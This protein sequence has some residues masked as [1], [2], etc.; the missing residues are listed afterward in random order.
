MPANALL[1]EMHHKIVNRKL[2]M[3]NAFCLCNTIVLFK[4]SPK[5]ATPSDNLSQIT[6]WPALNGTCVELKDQRQKHPRSLTFEMDME[7]WLEMKET[8]HVGST[9]V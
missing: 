7:I 2:E 9:A 8:V 3:L 1:F 5:Q 6:K 4:E